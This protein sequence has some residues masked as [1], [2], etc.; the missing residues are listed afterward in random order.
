MLKSAAASPLI[1][2][3]THA[4]MQAEAGKAMP[5]IGG[6]REIPEGLW[7]EQSRVAVLMW[8]R[9][10]HRSR[11]PP[12]ETAPCRKHTRGKHLLHMLV[13]KTHVIT[14]SHRRAI[15]LPA[16]LNAARIPHLEVA[17]FI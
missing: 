1:M 17:P 11:T 7:D 9:R 10:L 15:G 6:V 3:L 2:N 16:H 8:L 13:S 12:F 5:C 14:L 4:V